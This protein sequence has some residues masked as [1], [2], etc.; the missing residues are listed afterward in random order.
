MILPVSQLSCNALSLMRNSAKCI[1]MR[2]PDNYECG[3]CIE[4]R[5]IQGPICKKYLACI[6]QKSLGFLIN[7]GLLRVIFAGWT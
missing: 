4:I 3:F 5:T 6:D 7:A 2:S 1:A